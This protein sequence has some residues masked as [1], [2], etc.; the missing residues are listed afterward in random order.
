[1]TDND[2]Q[3]ED[4]HRPGLVR[5]TEDGEE[6]QVAVRNGRAVKSDALAQE[7]ELCGF[8]GRADTPQ[9]VGTRQVQ[10]RFDGAEVQTGPLPLSKANQLHLLLETLNGLDSYVIS[11]H[12]KDGDGVTHPSI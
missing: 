5:V 11:Y 6:E 9:P 8:N 4:G 12:G 3:T 7:L 10:I 1:M 2:E